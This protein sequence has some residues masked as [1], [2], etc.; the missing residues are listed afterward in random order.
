MLKMKHLLARVK[1]E[2]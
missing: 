2:D 1:F